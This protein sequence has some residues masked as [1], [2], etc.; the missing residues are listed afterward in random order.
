MLREHIREGDDLGGVVKRPVK[1]LDVLNR[2][3]MLLREINQ[4]TLTRDS[5]SADVIPRVSRVDTSR[6]TSEEGEGI[7]GNNATETVVMGVF[8]FDVVCLAFRRGNRYDRIK[9]ISIPNA[10][11][12]RKLASTFHI[13]KRDN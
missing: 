13:T 3:S 5:D 6:T 1:V 9:P 2:V 7:M 10:I 4:L 12:N 11:E 8:D